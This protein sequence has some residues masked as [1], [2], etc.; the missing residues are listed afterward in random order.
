MNRLP[1]EQPAAAPHRAG[2][3]AWLGSLLGTEINARSGLHCSERRGMT[4]RLAHIFIPIC[5]VALLAIVILMVVFGVARA[6][7]DQDKLLVV[8][9]EED[10]PPFAIGRTDE[11]ASGFTVDLWKV[12]AAEHGLNYTIRVRPFRQLLDEFKAGKIDVMINLA[13]S[14]ERRVFTDFSVPHVIVH[15]AIFVR[16]DESRIRSEADLA[17]RSIIVLNSDLAHDYAISRGWERQLVLVDTAAEGLKLLASGQHDAMLLSKL[18]GMQTLLELK[19]RNIKALGAKAGFSQR[20]SFAV[21]RG[22]SELLAKLNEGLALAKS[23]GTYDALYEQWFGVF[24][25]KEVSF[26]QVLKYLGPVALALLVLAVLLLVRQQERRKGVEALRRSHESLERRVEERTGELQRAVVELTNEITERKKAE[27]ALAQEMNERRQAEMRLQGVLD[28]S[29]VAIF[30]KSVPEGRYTLAN[31]DALAVIGVDSVG[32]TDLEIFPHEIAERLQA[33]DARVAASG[34]AESVEE[35][36]LL[37]DGERRDFLSI[38]FPLRNTEGRVTSLGGIALDITEQKRAEEAL[39]RSH[40]VL[41]R[42]VEERTGELRQMVER[43]KDEVA[44]R[45]RAERALRESEERYRTIVEAA[46]EGIWVLDSKACTTFVN[47][48]MSEMLGFAPEEMIGRNLMEFMDAEG[49]EQATRNLERRAQG[50]AEDHEFRFVRRDASDL[51]TIVSTSPIHDHQGQFSG[52]LGMV[53]DI[54]ERKRA[55][56]LIRANN[57]MLEGVTRVQQQF[58]IEADPRRW[59]DRVLTLL[60]ETTASEYGFIAEILRQPRGQP[61]LRSLAITNIAWNDE[62]RTFYEKSVQTGLEFHNLNTLFGAVITAGEIVIANDPAHDP[63]RGGLPSG[64]PPLRAFLGIPFFHGDEM[65]GMV[66]LANRAEGYDEKLAQRLDPILAT[67][68]SM[69]HAYRL[70][71]QRRKSDEELEFMATHDELTGLPNRTML[72]ERLG[73]LIETSRRDHASFALLFADLD[74]F[75][76]INDSLGHSTGDDLLK[77]V[78]KRLVRTLRENDT[79]ARFGGD[80]FVVI[81]ADLDTEALKHAMDRIVEV[82]AQPVRIGEQEIHTSV[83]IGVSLFPQDADDGERL[84][85]N[86]D[87]AMYL[88]K[89]RG[90]RSAYFFSARLRE[91]ADERLALESD[92]RVAMKKGDIYLAY[93]P[94]VDLRTGML[95]GV[96]ALVRWKHPRR[97]MVPPSS[98]IP[99]AEKAGLMNGLGHVVLDLAL[100]QMAQWKAEG[101]S[102]SRLAVNLSALQLRDAGLVGSMKALLQTH[103]IFPREVTLEIT[104]SALIVDPNIAEKRLHELKEAGILISLDDFGTGY[105]SLS[106]LRQFPIDELKIDQSFV[107]E[108]D[109]NSESRVIAQTVLAMARSLDRAV[110]AEGI[111][112]N[113]QLETLLNLGCRIGQGFLFSKPCA[114]EQ[115][116]ANYSHLLAT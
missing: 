36:A 34:Q 99:L 58:L 110:V 74:N 7:Q 35:S 114:P 22:N 111:E 28:Y 102:V 45:E 79:V 50:I 24:E 5:S 75:K 76:V 49:R 81:V 105:S 26:W 67:C 30:V 17:G 8:G 29:P 20:F 70:E 65:T 54:T 78:A 77:I 42:R 38:K 106:F 18:A 71:S 9:S 15:G 1:P 63:R 33:A 57:H 23:T 90:K 94:Q 46:H 48:R 44:E 4:R 96:E 13:Q 112:T 85:Q 107:A 3:L 2:I 32:K 51:W 80:E 89:E 40:E 88:A 101:K 104:E 43:L 55:D 37:P 16:E 68:S 10:Y 91:E 72:L 103:A 73:R 62:T 116:A 93:Q 100:K 109:T 52:A 86:A 25:A 84:L 113:S 11:A 14:E 19:I 21:H 60:L 59:F 97:G 12:V 6:Q 61:Y 69:V 82:V 53:L 56:D 83:S 27:Q 95:V 64:H 47:R 115:L 108:I 87:S 98:I 39:Q 31:P 41:E 66:G 92:L